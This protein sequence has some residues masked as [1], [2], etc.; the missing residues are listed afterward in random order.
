MTGFD[1]VIFATGFRYSFPFLP[2]YHN[3]SVGPKEQGPKN[4]P[5]PIVTD[6]TH[7]RNLYLDIFYIE[8]PTI[9]FVNS[10]Y[11]RLASTDL[12]DRYPFQ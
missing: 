6:G 11:T 7:L 12:P 10:M 4:L 8:E 9:G 3:P 1:A 5:Q 2:Q